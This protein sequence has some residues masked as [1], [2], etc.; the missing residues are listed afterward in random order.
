M[1]RL[2]VHFRSMEHVQDIITAFGG[3]TGTAEATGIAQQTISEWVTREPPEIPPWRR[4]AIIA[5]AQAR[6]IELSEDA[7]AYLQSTDRTPRR[8]AA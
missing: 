3:Q 7:V 2:S 8:K 1:Y 4:P 5:A 6:A